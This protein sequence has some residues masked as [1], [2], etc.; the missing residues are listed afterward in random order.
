MLVAEKIVGLPWISVSDR[1][2]FDGHAFLTEPQP[3]PEVG[4]PFF[5]SCG[6]PR[7]SLTR[8]CLIPKIAA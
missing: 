7:P 4:S 2:P 3:Q 8:L 6:T 1:F 5:A